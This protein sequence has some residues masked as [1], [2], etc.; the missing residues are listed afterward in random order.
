MGL[1]RGF[2][3]LTLTVAALDPRG[4]NRSERYGVRQSKRRAVP[5]SQVNVTGKALRWYSYGSDRL[6]R[7]T[8]T[9]A[10]LP[11]LLCVFHGALHVPCGDHSNTDMM[12][13]QENRGF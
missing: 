4:S 12:G 6:S 1:L 13:K 10:A 5:K 11:N 9:L 3:C 2:A 7:I 8:M